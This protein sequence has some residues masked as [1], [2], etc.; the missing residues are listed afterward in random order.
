ME[1]NH[2]RLG[3]QH[4]MVDG[5]DIQAVRTQGLQHR[6]DFARAHGD[7]AGDLSVVFI[8]GKGG[9]GIQSHAGV[10]RR[11]VLFEVKVVATQGEFVDRAEGFALAVNDV[12]KGDE[13]NSLLKNPPFI[14]NL[15][16]R[17]LV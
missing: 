12:V 14:C 16:V 9:P 13:I 17:E 1:K 4:V 8:S 15:N 10:N 3:I 7:V 6:V 2:V 11:S 5:N